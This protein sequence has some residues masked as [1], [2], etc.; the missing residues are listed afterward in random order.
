MKIILLPGLDGTGLLFRKLLTYIPY[1]IE[2]TV[3]SLDDLEGDTFLKQANEIAN[4]FEDDEILLVGESYSGRI[5][6]E[7]CGLLQEKIK[8]IVLLASFISSPS[9]ISKMA[10]YVPLFFLNPNP[11]SKWLL[12]LIGFNMKGSSNLVDA[13][14][15]SLSLSNKKKLKIRLKNIAHLDTPI[16]VYHYPV[17]YIMPDRDNLINKNSINILQS[18]FVNCELTTLKGGHFIGQSNP[19]DCAQII[20]RAFY[21]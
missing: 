16:K 19:F 4:K 10:S 3:I 11:M 6:Y 2:C 7:L 8:G 21:T 17:T 13:V 20:L 5:V 1:K 18:V 9:L 14:F 12:H 15:F